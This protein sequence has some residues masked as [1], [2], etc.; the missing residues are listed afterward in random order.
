VAEVEVGRLGD[1]SHQRKTRKAN[2][3]LVGKPE[4]T[5]FRKTRPR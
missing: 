5:S 3:L 1:E 4:E 2:I